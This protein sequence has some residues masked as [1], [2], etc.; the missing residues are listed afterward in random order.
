MV[1][2]VVSAYAHSRHSRIGHRPEHLDRFLASVR[3]GYR[4]KRQGTGR[5][6]QIQPRADHFLGDRIRNGYVALGVISLDNNRL[7]VGKAVLRETIHH[8]AYRVVQQHYGSV[9]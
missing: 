9:L 6:Q 1:Q 7:P 2:R 5:Q 8:A 3:I 4:L